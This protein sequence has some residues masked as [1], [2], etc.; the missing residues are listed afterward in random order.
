MHSLHRLPRSLGSC[1]HHLLLSPFALLPRHSSSTRAPPDA[2]PPAPPAD[3]ALPSVGGWYSSDSVERRLRRVRT[4]PPGA[5]GRTPP[6]PSEEDF[7]LASGAY[8]ATLAASAA[9]AEAAG[10]RASEAPASGAAPAAATAAP[11][12]S[13]WTPLPLARVAIGRVSLGNV[14]AL[15]RSYELLLLPL[16][17]SCAG[18]LRAELLLGDVPTGASRG[19]VLASAT[20]AGRGAADVAVQSLTLWADAESLSAAQAREDYAAAMKQLQTLF[21]EA[22]ASVQWARMAAWSADGRREEEES[23]RRGAL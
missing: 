23:E 13:T 7:W 6:P 10:G 17:R 22:P 9:A 21:V 3:A 15:V 14:P 16:Y 11:A 18:C 4:R 8:D 2:P 1:S 20:G 5:S 19:Q 12:D